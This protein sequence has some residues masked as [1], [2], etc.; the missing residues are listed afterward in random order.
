LAPFAVVSA[1]AT[2]ETTVE[3]KFNREVDPDTVASD[4]T[5]FLAYETVSG[6][7]LSITAASVSGD[8]VTLTTGPQTSGTEYT[9]IF[10]SVRDLALYTAIPADTELSFVGFATQPPLEVLSVTATSATTV[11]VVF[12]REVDPS[13]VSFD[14]FM[15]EGVAPAIDLAVTAVSVSGDTVTL[16]TSSQAPGGNYNLFVPAT[17]TDLSGVGMADDAIVSF[18]GYLAAPAEPRVVISQ[19][20]G[21]GGNSGAPYKNDF[22]E[23]FNAGTARAEL[24]GWSIQYASATGSSWTNKVDLAGSIPPGGYFLIQLAGG[25]NGAALPTPDLTG[26]ISMGTSGGKVA[27]VAST[28]TLS[29]SCPLED[30]IDFVGFGSANCYEGDD[31]TP[32][33]S[34]TLAVLRTLSG[35]TDAD[36][37]ASDFETGTPNPRNSATPA[38]QCT[39]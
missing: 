13:S 7:E 38:H 27:L 39:P 29:G 31:A 34:N 35:C 20:Y 33:P 32:A 25:T 16:T 5:Q 22:V 12:S 24:T 3:V 26:G 21:G 28:T 23:L 15:V 19:V 17:I 18:T 36:E 2:S 10:D 1:T 37:N 11:D 6:T 30:V 14:E 9:L 4:G 8:T